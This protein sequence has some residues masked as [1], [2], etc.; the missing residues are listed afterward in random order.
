VSVSTIG[1]R[2]TLTDAQLIDQ[3]KQELTAWFGVDQVSAW[4]HLRTYRIPF[5]QPNQA[6]PT[7]LRRPVSLGDGLYVCGDHRDDATFNGALVS[8]RRA[9]EALLAG[10]SAAGVPAAPAGAAVSV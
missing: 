3:V 7:N 8:G 2:D 1:T 6:P 10:G 5:A 9:A 4:S